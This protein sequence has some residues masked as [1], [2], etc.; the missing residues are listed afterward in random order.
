VGAGAP[1]A[2]GVGSCAS[3]AGAVPT[4][5]AAPVAA[6]F[7]NPRRPREVFCDFAINSPLFACKSL[8]W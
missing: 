8:L 1:P 4:S 5:A 3:T 7:K 2:A 6:L